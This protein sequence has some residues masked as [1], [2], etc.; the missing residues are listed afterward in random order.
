M[1]Q[2]TLTVQPALAAGDSGQVTVAP[3]PHELTPKE[4]LSI[5]DELL[6]GVK[7]KKGKVA[8]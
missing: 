6:D 5:I 7:P 1:R 3:K 2:D 8:K 4:V